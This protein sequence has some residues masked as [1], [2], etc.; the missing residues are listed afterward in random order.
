MRF[1]KN[2]YRAL[3]T[4]MKA[5]VVRSIKEKLQCRNRQIEDL[6]LKLTPTRTAV[7]NEDITSVLS[8]KGDM[9]PKLC[10]ILMGKAVNQ[11]FVH[12]WEED[13]TPVSW[14]GRVV[15]YR[16]KSAEHDVSYWHGDEMDDGEKYCLKVHQLAAD[17]YCGDLTFI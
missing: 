8:C 15:S 3:A 14:N 9:G 10:T 6:K 2:K 4:S 13:D 5:N 17:M 11:H 12:I 7:R 1:W 16:M